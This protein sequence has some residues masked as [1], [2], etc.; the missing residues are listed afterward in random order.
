MAND[1]DVIF[2]G[3]S[4]NEDV[5]RKFNLDLQSNIIEVTS[6]I[7]FKPWSKEDSAAYYYAISDTNNE[8]LVSIKAVSASTQAPL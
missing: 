2:A 5:T 1:D 4:F 6:D 7:R 3:V 8:N